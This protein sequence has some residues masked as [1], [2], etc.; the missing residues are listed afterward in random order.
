MFC[1]Y[2]GKDNKEDAVFCTSCGKKMKDT[3]AQ[4]Q[5]VI[6]E[7]T[8][9]IE[10]GKVTSK[11]KTAAIVIA[12]IG[13]PLTWLY[14]YKKDLAKFA[15]GFGSPFFIGFIGGAARSKELTALSV[16]A[17]LGAWIWSIIDASIK[18]KEWYEN[19]PNV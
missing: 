19:Y 3:V 9:I 13:G 8:T 6:S 4:T 16:L 10:T 12:I 15:I 2:C 18:R 5:N 17:T 1:Q 11:D 7:S 14:T